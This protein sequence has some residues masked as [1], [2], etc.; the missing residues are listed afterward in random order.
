MKKITKIAQNTTTVSTEQPSY[1]LLPIVVFLPTMK[2]SWLALI[3][4]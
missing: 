4:K 3:R 2:I 1:E